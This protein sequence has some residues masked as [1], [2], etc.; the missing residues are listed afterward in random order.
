VFFSVNGTRLLLGHNVA[1]PTVAQYMVRPTFSD[2]LATV[3]RLLWSETISQT[4]SQH[5]ASEKLPRQLKRIML[6]RLSLAA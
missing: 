5:E 2:A 6:D 4:P 3:R 1:E